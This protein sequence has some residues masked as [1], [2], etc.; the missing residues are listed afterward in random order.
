MVSMGPVYHGGDPAYAA[1]VVTKPLAEDFLHQSFVLLLDDAGRGGEY[2][3]GALS[4]GGIG[5]LTGLK[6]CMQQLGPCL[7]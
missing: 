5:R 2:S 7:T 6:Q 3:K 1:T 4:H